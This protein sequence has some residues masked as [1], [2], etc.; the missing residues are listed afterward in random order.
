MDA[1]NFF[2]LSQPCLIYAGVFAN[3]YKINCMKSLYDKIMKNTLFYFPM[4]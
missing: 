3:K 4:S 2:T 1:P